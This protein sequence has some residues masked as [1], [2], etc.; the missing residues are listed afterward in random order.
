MVKKDCDF[1][2]LQ[3]TIGIQIQGSTAYKRRLA[4]KIWKQ[5]RGLSKLSKILIQR[6]FKYHPQHQKIP[7]S[8]HSLTLDLKNQFGIGLKMLIFLKKLKTKS[9]FL[10]I[11]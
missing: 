1:L 4:P 11:F 5:K 9:L 2:K 7:L 3:S 6:H 8:T 10:N